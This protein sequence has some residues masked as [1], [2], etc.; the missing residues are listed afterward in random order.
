MRHLSSK[1]VLVVAALAS[2]VLPVASQAPAQKPSFEVASVKPNKSSDRR[3]KEEFFPNRYVGTNV[4]MRTLIH[5]A[6]GIPNPYG[7]RYYLKG[8]PDWLD[9]ERFDVEGKVEDGALPPTL[10]AK[11]RNDQIRLMLQTLLADR[12]QLNV[13]HEIKEVPIYEMVVA[14]NGPKL[15]KAT[16]DRECP[17]IPVGSTACPGRFTGGMRTGLMAKAVDLSELA[18][19]L[20]AIAD[21]PILNKTGIPGLFDITTTPFKPAPGSRIEGNADPETI[22]TIF[23]M[24][25]EQLGLKLESAKGPVEVLVIDHVERPSEN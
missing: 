24:L 4:T 11:D 7:Q 23:T 6:Y 16:E 12:F 20:S 10:S 13:H 14:K 25:P 5:A 19:F 8:G 2:A 1:V 9:S 18:Q 17:G 21:R 22:P 15:Q 3:P